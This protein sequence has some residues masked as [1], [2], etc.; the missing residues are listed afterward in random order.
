MAE[1]RLKDVT[2][3]FGD[4]KAVDKANLTIEDSESLQPQNLE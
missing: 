4:L 2:K 3:M 1:V